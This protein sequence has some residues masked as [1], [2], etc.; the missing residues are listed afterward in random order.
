M[1][2]EPGSL[3]VWGGG[4]PGV[5]LII[6]AADGAQVLGLGA[7]VAGSGVPVALLAEEGISWLSSSGEPVSH[8]LA[9][10]RARR[11]QLSRL[12]L[13]FAA[14]VPQPP[15]A[16]ADSSLSR[17]AMPVVK[18]ARL[19]LLAGS[20]RRAGH[21]SGLA[22]GSGS[23]GASS[24]LRTKAPA[25]PLARRLC[26]CVRRERARAVRPGPQP[27]RAT[28]PAPANPAGQA[29]HRNL[30]RRGSQRGPDRRRSPLHVWAGL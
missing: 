4:L 1:V 18:H 7:P 14:R 16:R 8:L 29:H 9:E 20:R 10:R 23:R 26:I 17:V 3:F 25:H 24:C 21:G 2:A 13:P 22:A 6:D 28:A 12:T 30:V 15:L 19:R 27:R 5:P 11:N